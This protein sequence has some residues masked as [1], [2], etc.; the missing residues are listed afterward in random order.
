MSADSILIRQRRRIVMQ[1][2]N[3]F[4]P[5]RVYAGTVWRVVIGIDPDYEKSLFIKD[6]FYLQ[7]KGYVELV[8]N[9]LTNSG[10]FEEKFVLLTAEGKEIAEQTMIDPAL[11]I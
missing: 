7:K 9:P 4:F 3:S 1:A 6:V 2:L 10:K 8:I 5:T 11:K